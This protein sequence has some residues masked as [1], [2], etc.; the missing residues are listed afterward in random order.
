MWISEEEEEEE[1]ILQSNQMN[2]VRIMQIVH[3]GPR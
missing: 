1:E 3:A 2:T